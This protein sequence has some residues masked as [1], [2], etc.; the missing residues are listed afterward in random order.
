[1][2]PQFVGNRS[3]DVATIFWQQE[4]GSR[5]DLLAT[6]VQKP[7]QFVGNRSTEAATI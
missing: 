1:M 2:S 5:H 6:G 7:P 3:T 4:F